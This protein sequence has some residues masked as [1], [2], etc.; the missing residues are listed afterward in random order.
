MWSV[1]YAFIVAGSTAAVLNETA[2]AVSGAVS[3]GGSV[4]GT[5]GI[6]LGVTGVCLFGICTGGLCENRWFDCGWSGVC[7]CL[8][9]GSAKAK[10]S[11]MHANVEQV[12][13]RG[14][15]TLQAFA[16]CLKLV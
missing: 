5:V 1:I 3:G 9:G 15:D 7:L 4:G 13:K 16:N 10:V 11:A 14:G 6:A 8:P 12:R 2:G